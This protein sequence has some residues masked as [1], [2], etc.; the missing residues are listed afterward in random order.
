MKNSSY[1]AHGTRMAPRSQ[2][3]S[4]RLGAARKVAPRAQLREHQ[5]ASDR[6][7]VHVVHLDAV[8]S[9]LAG[10]PGERALDDVTELLGVLSN[11]TRLKLLLALRPDAA[12]ARTELCVC[13]LAA[14]AGASTSLTSHQLRLL[15]A[16]GLVRQRRV[17]KLA[18]YRLV[19]GPIVS[20]LADVAR[21]ARRPILAG[22]ARP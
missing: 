1:V 2:G 7:Q 17:G 22:A 16:S 21:L 5:L 18:L 11:P 19:D 15:R 8:R 14:V 4:P 12:E 6:C 13:D 9:A 10:L 3:R 20:L